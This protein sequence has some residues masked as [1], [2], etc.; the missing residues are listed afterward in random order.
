MLHSS[1]HAGDAFPALPAVLAMH[2]GTCSPRTVQTCFHRNLLGCHRTPVLAFVQEFRTK[3]M[4]TVTKLCTQACSNACWRIH[5]FGFRNSKVAVHLG[6]GMATLLICQAQP[7]FS[8]EYQAAV[9]QKVKS[10]AKPEH[11]RTSSADYVCHCTTDRSEDLK[12]A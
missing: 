3:P 4:D 8:L 5:L 2:V 12:A 9:F 6:S 1:L 10:L 7:V 11:D